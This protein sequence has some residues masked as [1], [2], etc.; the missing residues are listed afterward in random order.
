MLSAAKNRQEEGK[1]PPPGTEPSPGRDFLGALLLL[2]VSFSFIV[3]SLQIPFQNPE[4]KWYTSPGIFA[5]TMA[6]CLG[7]CSLVVGYRGLRGWVKKRPANRSGSWL[8]G[9]RSWGMGRFLA[10][11]AI[12][13]VYLILLGRVPFLLASVGLILIFGTVFREGR[14]LD[15]LRPASIAALVV[16]IFS[17]T[18]MKVFGIIFP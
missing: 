16:V 5:L 6:V 4:W 3:A 7:G 10:S 8:E 18:I 1:S 17:Y 15:G 9:L 13:L 12:I 14:F 11:V 2:I